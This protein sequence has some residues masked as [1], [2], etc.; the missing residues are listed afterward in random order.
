VLFYVFA[1]LTKLFW[2]LQTSSSSAA[3]T[4][5]GII[6]PKTTAWNPDTTYLSSI[7]LLEL[8]HVFAGL[9]GSLP[10]ARVTVEGKEEKVAAATDEDTLFPESSE[11]HVRVSVG[12]TCSAPCV[13]LQQTEYEEDWI[14]PCMV[15]AELPTATQADDDSC[16]PLN[17]SIGQTSTGRGAETINEIT[18]QISRNL[19][20]SNS[21]TGVQPAVFP[22]P[23]SAALAT[24][25]GD[26]VHM[27]QETR[28]MREVVIE[29]CSNI[30]GST[31]NLVFN[32]VMCHPSNSFEVDFSTLRKKVEHVMLDM[33]KEDVLCEIPFY[34]LHYEAAPLYVVK[35]HEFFYLTKPRDVDEVCDSSATNTTI[36]EERMCP[37]T[38]CDGCRNQKLFNAFASRVTAVLS[39]KPKCSINIIHSELPMLTPTHVCILMSRL[40]AD[41]IVEKCIVH[42]KVVVSNMFA[43]PMDSKD[44]I[45]YSLS[46]SQW[47]K[48]D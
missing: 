1:G 10:A 36:Y 6:S 29:K 18:V 27:T 9:D 25:G 28:W 4:V 47:K 31:V 37:W 30:Q 41:G 32:A 5:G 44:L 39:R 2:S 42:S 20:E 14:A 11:T 48:N 40:I 38:R 33:C 35:A 15:C 16:R 13:R 17:K 46:S 23:A 8:L 43:E 26:V 24:A 3:H 21:R 12:K 19:T 22:A 34:N 7:E 45:C